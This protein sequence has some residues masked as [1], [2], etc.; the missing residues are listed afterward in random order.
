MKLPTYYMFI[1]ESGDASLNNKGRF[2]FLSTVIISRSDF[3]II[4]GYMKL[5][6]R[7][8]FMDDFKILHA[9]IWTPVSKIPPNSYAKG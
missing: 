3:E 5:L 7:R 8:F 1:D 9:S 4:Q 2:F 6:K